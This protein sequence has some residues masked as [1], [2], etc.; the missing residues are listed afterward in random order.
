MLVFYALRTSINV[1]IGISFV[2][3]FGIRMHM[4]LVVASVFSIGKSI[5]IKN[6]EYI[7]CVSVRVNFS[8]TVNV[9]ISINTSVSISIR[10]NGAFHISFNIRRSTSISIN[11]G[12]R[13]HT[14]IYQ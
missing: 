10:L 11:V 1:N 5:S 6:N 3:V 9:S 12:T 2:A 14:L 7:I 4:T 8:A 13:V